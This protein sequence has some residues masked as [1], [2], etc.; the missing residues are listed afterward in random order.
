MP[1]RQACGSQ[2]PFY[3]LKG[4]A[5]N[6]A[7]FAPAIEDSSWQRPLHDDAAIRVP[8]NQPRG[9]LGL[10]SS[11][12][13][14]KYA[15]TTWLHVSREWGGVRWIWWSGAEVATQ[16]NK[17]ARRTAQERCP[18]AGSATK[19]SMRAYVAC[20]IR[21]RKHVVQ[22]DGVHQSGDAELAAKSS[23]NGFGSENDISA[24]RLPQRK[25]IETASPLGF[26]PSPPSQCGSNSPAPTRCTKHVW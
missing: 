8:L 22:R 21:L 7:K 4:Q 12:D 18:Y 24:V 19:P 15:F 6:D 5:L 3:Q 14:K 20:A 11:G 13:T 16:E 26:R 1:P 10:I 25:V 2:P 9:E 23:Q 17:K